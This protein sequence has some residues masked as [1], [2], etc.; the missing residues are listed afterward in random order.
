MTLRLRL[1]I[2]LLVLLTVG[3][4][5]F[6][7]VVTS[8]YSHSQY[9]RLD[10][11]LRSQAP[12][13]IARLRAQLGLGEGPGGFEGR[14]LGGDS[15]GPTRLGSD[16][17]LQIRDVD[18][19]VYSGTFSDG[20]NVPDLPAQLDSGNAQS[21]FLTVGSSRG[22]GQWR[23]LVSGPDR[24]SG[25]T[26]IVA[27][28]LTDVSGPLERLIVIEVLAAAGLLALLGTGS[29][30]ILRR[31]LRPLEQMATSAGSITTG[32]LQGN[33]PAERVAPADSQTEV[34]RLG[35]AIN[36]ML[37]EIEAAFEERDATES[38]LRQFL[39]DAS[40]EL[41]TPL[42][43]IGGFAELFRMGAAD[44]PAKLA[45]ILRR[46]EEESDRMK[47]LV[48]E[49]LLL[50][51]L[52][53]TR[54]TERVVVDLAVLCADACTDASATQ[55]DRRITLVAPEP[56]TFSGDRD[57]LRQAIANLVTNALR[58]TPPGT[59]IEVGVRRDPG[60]AVIWV[61]D[62]GAGLDAAAA[63]H[64]F[65]RFWRADS[66]RTGTGTGLGLA[67][68]AAIAEEHNGSVAVENA[69]EGGA[70]FTLRLPY[71]TG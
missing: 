68:V 32:S 50:A 15:G 13:A 58:H 41:R 42:T 6:G 14:P 60:D 21:R 59:P 45:V 48:E 47:I 33:G 30:L 9:Q 39:A 54:P 40:H 29:W 56:V 7:V 5:V 46:I 2:A 70:C 17:Y 31:G 57:H 61:R 44:D 65:D 20:V 35:L 43:T 62:H 28:P 8:F 64:A 36:T 10:E 27:V 11:R 63:D 34:G 18:G 67:I 51:R 23:V 16:A 53:E 55:P 3:L 69:P 25:I 19:N 66:A 24:F 52:D 71:E 4:A 37:G 26:S 22:S 1:V 49:L 12:F 38:R